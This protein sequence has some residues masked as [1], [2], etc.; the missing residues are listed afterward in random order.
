M[1]Q[2]PPQNILPLSS[3]AVDLILKLMEKD[4]S[5]RYG[6]L[7]HGARDIFTH[8][9]FTEVDWERLKSQGYPVPY[10]PSI[11]HGGDASA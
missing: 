1:I 7:R 11:Q 6:N 9:W 3:R 8:P 2:W 4:P 10:V 5:N